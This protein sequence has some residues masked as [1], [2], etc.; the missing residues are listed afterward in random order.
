TRPTPSLVESLAS[1]RTKYAVLFVA[2]SSVE[3]SFLTIIKEPGMLS[4]IASC[5]QP[6]KKQSRLP[7]SKRQSRLR[8]HFHLSRRRIAMAF[9]M[10]KMGPISVPGY[11]VARQRLWR[12]TPELWRTTP[13]LWRG[14]PAHLIDTTHRL[15]I[16]RKQN[17]RKGLRL[18]REPR[19]FFLKSWNTR[20]IALLF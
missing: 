8:M 10:S 17:T 14:T 11:G 16:F 13:E 12:G 4:I 1:E 7:K 3:S 2:L 18:R 6:S 20:F 5:R 15:Q 9:N 19:S